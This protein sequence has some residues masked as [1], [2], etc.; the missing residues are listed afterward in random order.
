MR[1]GNFYKA[2]LLYIHQEKRDTP[3]ANMQKEY[4]SSKK[5][6]ENKSENSGIKINRSPENPTKSRVTR[7]RRPYRSDAQPYDESDEEET[8]MDAESAEE[9]GSPEQKQPSS[10]KS[11]KDMNLEEKVYY[12]ANAPALSPRL[13]CKI[14]MD[15]HSVRGKIVDFVDNDV[16]VLVGK[17]KSPT[18]VPFDQVIDI[19]LIGF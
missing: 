18:K 3:G 12:F 13:R 1:S 15:D 10:D 4:V 14:Q 8:V 19:Q 17:R 2:P 9:K 7:R 11:F 5:Q 6:S 16:Y